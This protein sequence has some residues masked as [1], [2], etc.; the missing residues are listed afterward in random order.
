VYVLTAA[1][2]AVEEREAERRVL[3]EEDELQYH[4]PDESENSC[5]C[6]CCRHKHCFWHFL[7]LVVDPLDANFSCAMSCHMLTGLRF[8]FGG[9]L[10]ELK[11]V[12]CAQ[13]LNSF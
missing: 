12:Y 7:S 2:R 1:Q 11:K 6:P 13:E 8:C 9:F 3:L 4:T 10:L 5:H